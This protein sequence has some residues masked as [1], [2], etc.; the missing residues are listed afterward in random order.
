MS[1]AIDT[2]EKIR[3]HP[4]VHWEKADISEEQV[5]E[6][7]RPFKFGNFASASHPQND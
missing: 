6:D 7:S 1:S 4:V 3:L 2:A 5:S